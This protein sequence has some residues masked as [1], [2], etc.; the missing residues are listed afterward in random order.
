MFDIFACLRDDHDLRLVVLAAIICLLSTSTAVLM[1]RQTPRHGIAPLHKWAALGGIATGFGIWST[2]FIA[3]LGYDPGVVIGYRPVLTLGSLAIVLA[4]TTGAFTFLVRRQSVA[5]TTVAAVVTGSGFAVMHYAGMAAL[6]MPARI[7]WDWRYVAASVALAIAP[8]I[9]ALHLAAGRR[10]RLSGVTSAILLAGSVIGLHFTG[11]AAISLVPE[12][13]PEG[14]LLLSPQTMA[15]VVTAV[16]LALLALCIASWWLY[17]QTAAVIIVS[18]RQFSALVMGITDCAIY[19]LDSNGRVANWNMG[20]QRLTGFGADEVVGRLDLS[21]FYTDEERA[22]DGP[23]RALAHAKASGK[24]TGEGWRLRKDGSRFWAHVTIERVADEEGRL[25][26]YAKITRDMT[27]FKDN[28]DQMNEARRHLDAALEHMHQGLCLFDADERLILHNSRFAQIW[29]LPPDSFLPGMSMTELARISLEARTGTEVSEERLA[30]A[31]DMLRQTLVG[32]NPS[33]LIHEFNEN[34]AISISS[35]SL[36]DGGL[37][38]THEDITERCRSEAQIAYLAHHDGLT[39]L[40]NRSKFTR[41]LDREIENA[42]LRNRRVALVAIDIDRFKEINDI[43]GHGAGDDVLRSFA[44][45]LTDALEDEECAARI[46]GDEFVVA[47]IFDSQAQLDDFVARI[48]GCS[49]PRHGHMP[50]F[51]VAASLGIAVYPADAQSRDALLNNADLA[52][53][54]AKASPTEQICFYQS[55][56]DEHARYRRQ[57]ANDLRQAIDRSEFHVAYQPQKLLQS[58]KIVSYEAL[59]RWTHPRLGSISP[60]EFIPLAEETGEIFR[61]GEWVLRQACAEA[62]QWDEEI[63]IAVNLSSVQLMQPDL[64]ETIAS[65]LLEMRLPPRRLELEITETA[66]ITD[67]VRAL[68]ILRRI[69]NLG[70]RIAMDDFGTGYS[71]LDTLHSFPFDKI[72]IDKSFL[73]GAE[74][75]G[76]ARAIIRAILG[77]GRSL[78]IPV[79]AEGVETEGQLQLLRDE[80]C[81]EAQGYLLGMPLIA[82]RGQ[83]CAAILG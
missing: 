22:G 57:L 1:V 66:F 68:H 59:L 11:V 75:S 51:Q 82:P 76:Q 81:E 4:T 48:E 17:R 70:I 56:M 65:I 83:A 21:R 39:G 73:L 28:Q 7:I 67:K 42:G 29:K 64:P 46:G 19:M 32:D 43:H 25:I 20:A 69:K 60:D 44:L 8:L 31:C 38:C 10:D 80:G 41:W 55:G 63:G 54:R 3:M 62:A 15:G 2:H 71:S 40:P 36:P 78:D 27:Q 5:A 77:L 50:L 14:L 23:K 58:D 26:G 16:S 30:A 24:Y 47:K 35:R 33:P 13:M 34:F 6:E 12:R 74:Q 49:S 18:E 37:V 61:I 9:P 53:Y 72:K 52:M 45:S 79:L